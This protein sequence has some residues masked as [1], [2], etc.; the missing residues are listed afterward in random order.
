MNHKKIS[1]VLPL[2]N[3][4]ATIERAL[5]SLSDQTK[6]PYEIIVVNDGS[7]DNSLVI[8][9]RFKSE[10]PELVL[11]VMCQ[12]NQGVSA[13]RNHGI[14]AVTSEYIAFLDGDDT[15]EPRFIEQIADLIDRYPGAGVLCTKYRFISSDGIKREARW[16]GINGDMQHGLVKNYF[17]MA[18]KGDLP[19]S[20]SSVCIAK[21]AIK[22]AGGFP[23]GQ[24]MGE[25]QWLWSLLALNER[26]VY[27][28][29]VLSNYY[30]ETS[31]SLMNTKTPDAE[32]PFSMM[33]QDLLDTRATVGDLDK[34]IRA[35]IRMHLLDLVRRNL[36]ASRLDVSSQLLQDSR[37]KGWYVKP[38]YWRV[39]LLL[40]SAI[41][42]VKG[43]K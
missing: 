12:T 37:L 11:R 14:A 39:R 35:M 31:G 33:L 23:V 34:D 25:D 3:K 8:L 5:L 42:R 32:L 43:I 18:A 16:A 2:Y 6:K 4:Q 10:H 27:S 41:N 30:A 22:K 29:M 15:Y 13:A 9:E 1:V 24:Q 19:L 36:Q 7:T 28:N 40:L 38:L 17:R 26:I 20:A 21:P